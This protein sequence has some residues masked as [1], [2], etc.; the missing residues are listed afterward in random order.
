MQFGEGRNQLGELNGFGLIRELAI[1]DND[2]TG[3]CERRHAF[4][5]ELNTAAHFAHQRI[6]APSAPRK[7]PEQQKQL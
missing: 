1:R 6:D 2:E 4:F 7:L 5:D 3:G